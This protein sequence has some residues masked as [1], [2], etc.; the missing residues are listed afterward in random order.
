MRFLRIYVGKIPFIKIYS[1]VVLPTQCRFVQ[2]D[3]LLYWRKH[4]NGTEPVHPRHRQVNLHMKIVEAYRG[5]MHSVKSTT[6]EYTTAWSTK[7]V[8]SI[9]IL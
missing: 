4:N 8:I 5:Y 7:A 1:H 2:Y 3:Q 9:F 6:V